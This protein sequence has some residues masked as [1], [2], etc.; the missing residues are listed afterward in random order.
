MAVAR[1]GY[2]FKT[3]DE[4]VRNP[5]A[6]DELE[7]IK[8]EIRRENPYSGNRVAGYPHGF[9]PQRTFRFESFYNRDPHDTIVRYFA[10]NGNT[11]EIR[12]LPP[13][14]EFLS[15]S[16]ALEARIIR[17]LQTH[18][19]TGAQAALEP[20][21]HY[22]PPPPEP[23][24]PARPVVNARRTRKG[25]KRTQRKTRRTCSRRSTH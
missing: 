17:F 13:D 8:A 6:R 21:A 7:A 12:M 16:P 3:F 9:H 22:V 5:V 14:D 10:I 23:P 1:N 20:P 19:R 2:W 25:G 11:G 15:I 4:L 18:A 24:A